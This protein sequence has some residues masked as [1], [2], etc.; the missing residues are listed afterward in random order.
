MIAHADDGPIV[1]PV[2]ARAP[3]LGAV[4]AAI[5][6]IR[7]FVLRCLGDRAIGFRS[8]V[9]RLS[10]VVPMFAGLTRLARAAFPWGMGALATGPAGAAVTRR[11]VVRGCL[12]I[13]RQ[14]VERRALLPIDGAGDELFDFGNFW[15]DRATIE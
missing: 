4:M 10:R 6:V 5:L 12:V 13:L 1:V 15:S 7:R 9:V 3:A 8:S 11:A 2:V 14:R